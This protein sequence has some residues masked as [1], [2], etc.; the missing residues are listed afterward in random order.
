MERTAFADLLEA[1]ELHNVKLGALHFVEIV[2]VNRDLGMTLDAE[3][4][5][6]PKEEAPAAASH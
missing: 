4:L 1:A 5:E 2:Q 6:A 3:L